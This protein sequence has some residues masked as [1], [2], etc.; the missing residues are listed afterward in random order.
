MNLIVKLIDKREQHY[1]W[2]DSGDRNIIF[3][4]LEMVEGVYFIIKKEKAKMTECKTMW[5]CLVG[6]G[7]LAVLAVVLYAGFYLS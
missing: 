3:S 4:L 2:V 7:I 1:Y 5:L 6:L